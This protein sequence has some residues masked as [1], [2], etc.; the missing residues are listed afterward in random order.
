MKLAEL[1][2]S[3]VTLKCSLPNGDLETLI[4][5]TSDEDL[6]N[7]IEEYDRG[8]SSL[9]H[10]LKVR[11]ILV[12]P[13]SLKKV[14]PSPS[15]APSADHSPTRSTHSSTD[16]LPSSLAYRFVRPVAYP[17]G[18]RN[19]SGKACCYTGQFDGSPRFLYCGPRCNF[20]CH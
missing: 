13:K 7:I 12:P 5:I 11:A 20:F 9:A 4:S 2:G 18:V 10:P 1:C 6:A 15:S 3:S 14:S 8:S 16:S 17:V 19:G